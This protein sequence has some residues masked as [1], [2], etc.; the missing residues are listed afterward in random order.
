MVLESEHNVE[1]IAALQADNRSNRPAI[2]KTISLEGQIIDRIDYKTVT[3]VKVRVAAAAKDLLLSC[4]TMPLLLREAS[5]MEW[6]H[7]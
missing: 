2:D 5:S 4:T 7:V 6:D 3:R 1:G